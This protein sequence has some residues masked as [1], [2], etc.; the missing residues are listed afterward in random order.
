MNVFYMIYSNKE[1][2]QKA[3]NEFVEKK[4]K[5]FLEDN[6]VLV[7]SFQDALK[8]LANIK[9]LAKLAFCASNDYKR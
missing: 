2:F 1:D 6:L 8:Q 4:V 3:M 9:S 5:E 7:C